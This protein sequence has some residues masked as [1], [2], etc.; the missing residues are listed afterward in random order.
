VEESI[1]GYA[2]KAKNNTLE[3]EDMAGGTFTISNGTI[4]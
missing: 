2:A 4:R 1:A 3:M